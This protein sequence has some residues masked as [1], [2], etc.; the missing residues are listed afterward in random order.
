M[1]N[2]GYDYSEGA[3]TMFKTRLLSS[4]V[5]VAIL[6]VAM[7][8]G[9]FILFSLLLSISLIGVSEFYRAV[10]TEEEKAID[11]K[12]DALD[13]T[14]YLGVLAYYGIMLATEKEQYLFFAIIIILTIVMF[15]Y[16]FSYPRFSSGKMISTIFG[17]IYVAV[18]LSFIYLTRISENGLYLV[19]LI[20]I[21]SWICD[22]SAYCVGM[23]FGKHK[24]APRLSPKKSVEG[25]IGGMVG[26][27]LVGAVYGYAVKDQIGAGQTVVW[28]FAIICAL[29]AIAS[30]IGD[31]SASAIKRNHN[32]KDYGKLIPGHGGILDRFDSVLVTAPMIYILSVIFSGCIGK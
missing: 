28:I 14:G 9:R 4:I 17:V 5:L 25:A 10:R 29:G 1:L 27:G 16:V 22:T 31:L 12:A 3:D 13:I 32:I 18:M 26:S 15:V 19:W 23:L 21:S 8:T 6:A 11:V 30:Q 20:F 2:S 24:L 7:F